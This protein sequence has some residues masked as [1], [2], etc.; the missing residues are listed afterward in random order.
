MKMAITNQERSEGK[1][2][3]RKFPLG[4]LVATPGAM[5]ALTDVE[6]ADA[7]LR[8]VRGDWGDVDAVDWREND[9]AVKQEL[10]IF[11]V[12]HTKDGTKFWVI[13]EADRSVT[14]VMLPED[15]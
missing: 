11:S 2:R 9:L 12:Y 5:A 6:A 15:Y 10:R 13:T 4:S 7:V 8:H 3:S 14:T 1:A